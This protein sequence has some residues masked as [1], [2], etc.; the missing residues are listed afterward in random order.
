MERMNY[1]ALVKTEPPEDLVS[2]ALQKG[3]LSKEY[4][5]YK[6]GWEYVPLEERRQ[7]AVEVVCTACGKHFVADKVHAG[8]CHCSYAPAP[9]GF[10]DPATM[11][12]VISGND[13]LCPVCGEQVTAKHVGQ[14]SRGGIEDFA[15]ITTVYRLPVENAKDRLVVQ[16]WQICRI[17]QKDGTCSFHTMP[18]TAWVVEENKVVRLMG[19]T[20][21]FSTLILHSLEQRKTFLDDY[22]HC[23][24]VYPWDPAVLDGT[25]AEHS[26]LDLYIGQ[27][28]VRLVAYLAMW[29]RKPTVENLV[30]HGYGRLVDQLI[31][32]EQHTGTYE[33]KKGIPKLPVIN[34]RDK[35]PNR[36]LR[37]S[38]E[39]FKR[40]ADYM[41]AE[42][43]EL[44]IW[45]RENGLEVTMPAGLDRINKMGAY[46]SRQLLDLVGA[47]EFWKTLRYI[48]RNGNDFVMLRDYWQMAAQLKMDLDNT[49]VRWPKDLKAAHDRAAIR[50][51]EEKDAILKQCFKERRAALE[52]Y[53]WTAGNILIRP[54][55]TEA[56]LRREGKILHHC[57]AT[58][59]KNH[60]DGK[61]AIF[62]IRRADAPKEPW[63]TLELDEKELRVKQNRGKYN[64]ARTEEIQAFENEWLEHLRTMS[65]KQAKKSKRKGA[66][67]A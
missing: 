30:M 29:R 12:T 4:L 45:A 52:K 57:V 2:W 16:E 34:W 62:F 7:P 23:S 27:G 49:Q 3:A 59:A 36:M 24:L 42:K 50:C 9:F 51:Q 22:G 38:K 32:K 17:T 5:I 21:Y 11:E 10:L 64:C 47:A 54:A 46:T 55:A 66:T 28:G 1:E 26:K 35:R 19:Y 63:Y 41:T 8:G 56:E 60:A 58:Y 43:F 6:A 37:M 13:C 39:E 15:Y 67:A 44:L 20:R 48:E 31:D 33:R 53:S 65:R 14:I 40:L 25:T 61:T 18:W